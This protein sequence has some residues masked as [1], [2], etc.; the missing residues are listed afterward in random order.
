ML[1]LLQ[2]ITDCRCVYVTPMQSLA[3]QA[4]RVLKHIHKVSVVF[5]RV[6]ERSSVNQSHGRMKKRKTPKTR[7]QPLEVASL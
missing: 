3:D 4:S 1:R 2:Q 7:Y 6:Q 5:S